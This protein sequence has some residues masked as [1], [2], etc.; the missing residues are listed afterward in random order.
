VRL[1][2]LNIEGFRSLKNVTWQPGQLN[3]LIDP[4][5]SGKTNLIKALRLMSHSA[6]GKLYDSLV[7]MEGVSP[8]LWDGQVDKIKWNMQLTSDNHTLDYQFSLR[9]RQKSGTYFIHEES[10]KNLPDNKEILPLELIKKIKYIPV[11]IPASIAT[12]TSS[13]DDFIFTETILSQIERYEK[14]PEIK[15]LRQ[16]LNNLMVYNDMPVDENTSLRRASVLRV[17]K[18]V[19]QDGQNLVPVLHTLY[20]SDRDFKVDIDMGMNAAF[21]SELLELVFPPAEDQRIQLKL[22][23]KSMKRA[24]SMS[25]LSDGT[26]KYLLLLTILANPELPPL[27][28]IDEPENGL[29]PGM[30]PVTAEYAWSASEKCQVVLSTHSSELLNCL[31]EFNPTVT[32]C[33]NENGETQLK[34]CD[35]KELSRWLKK[36]SLGNLFLSGELED[37]YNNIQRISL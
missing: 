25:D 37:I 23:W 2:S 27:L 20:S 32:V 28:I 13:S 26:V 19:N 21:A 33:S 15:Q 5:G 3:V 18:K 11:D 30:L 14:T 24:Q 4:K 16:W 9:Y 17:E 31:G 29:H 35:G 6:S 22:N 7:N 36:Y 12:N 10:L 1:D 34:N 8:L